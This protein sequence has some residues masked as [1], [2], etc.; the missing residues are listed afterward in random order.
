M[1]ILLVSSV[2][3]QLLRSFSVAFALPL[4]LALFDGDNLSALSFAVAGGLCWG[5]G[6][7]A[8]MGFTRPRV[9]FRAEALAIVALSW[10]AL[11][12]ISA[13]PYLFHGLTLLNALFESMS[14]LTTTGATIL[15][16]FDQPRAFFL[17]RAMTQWVGGLGIIALFVV[18]LPRLGIAG[19]QIFFAEASSAPSEAVTPQVKQA[20]RWLWLLYVVLTG[21]CAVLLMVF[22][23]SLFE[24]VCHS[25]TTL[26]AGGFSPNGESILGY[27][28]PGIEWVLVVFM[29]LSGASYPLQLKVYTGELL[30]FFRDGEF[31]LYLS[32]TFV[33]IVALS[34]V[35]T[36][37]GVLSADALRLAA[38]QITSLGSSTGFASVDFN[39]WSDSA[40]AILVCIM[41]IGGCAGSA[42]GGPKCVRYLLVARHILREFK[43]VLHPR[44][45]LPLLYNHAAVPAAIMRP[46][47]TLVCL[48][49][50]G[51]LGLGLVLVIIEGDLVLGFSA[52]LACLG[53]V[54][55][56][57]GEA[58]PMGS[59]AGFTPLSRGL[60]F[61]AMWIGRLEILTVLALLHPHVWR[62]LKLS[63]RA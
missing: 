25:M 31:L 40:K 21:I 46:V 32:A 48:Y 57:F 16:D 55:P 2:I 49:L 23:M 17:G 39:A 6:A 60:L 30:G 29:F 42:A 10:L 7:L 63:R 62:N 27:H 18:V 61:A 50:F 47:F 24:A 9:L 20:A 54:G 13:V 15:T 44:A 19:R 58:G 5:V 45:V 14:G 34:L 59:F 8:S 26:A 22:G 12:M 3:G 38:F 28:S 4:L 43:Q 52:A 53:N 36:G 51:Y 35:L 56:G 37:D 11:S 41:V 1:R 33:C